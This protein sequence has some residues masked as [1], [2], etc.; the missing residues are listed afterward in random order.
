MKNYR[1]RGV[2]NL[3]AVVV[4]CLM[5]V[6]AAG[7]QSTDM[8]S[9][10]ALTSNVITGEGDGKGES[11]Y[12]SFIATQ[13]DV[14]LTLDAKTDNYSTRVEVVF[15]TEDGKE[16]LQVTAVAGD[17]MER[18]V[19]TKHFVREQKVILRISTREDKQVKLLTYK[20]RL[21]GS[22]KIQ[23]AMIAPATPAAPDSPAAPA[24]AIVPDTPAPASAAT[25]PAPANVAPDVT[26]PAAAA[27]PVT[28][29]PPAAAV[30]ATPGKQPSTGAKVKEKVKA[31]A[32]ESAKKVA[33]GLLNEGQVK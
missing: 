23:A 15:L 5:T 30:P 33:D 8:D 28:D 22:V 4:W 10:T 7:A 17:K 11:L 32:K 24:P 27:V 18:V 21:D 9:P 20:I 13:G 3:V 31:K 6:M 25:D 12:Y 1:D 14:K 2:L 29:A 19:G 16:L 26:A